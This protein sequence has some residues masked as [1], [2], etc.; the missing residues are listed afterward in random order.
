VEA[1]FMKKSL[2][3]FAALFAFLTGFASAKV[4]VRKDAG[5]WRMF[6]GNREVEIKGITWSN[7]PIGMDYNYSLWRMD[8]DFIMATLNT[9]MPMLQ[10]MGVNV[11]RSFDDVPPKW[12]EY[13]YENYGIYTLINNLMGRY[14]VTVKGK[15]VFPTD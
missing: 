11:I 9:D 3:V 7:T 5:G 6:D 4:T 13:I 14:G 8:D 12:V 2:I 1:G 15:W 10:A